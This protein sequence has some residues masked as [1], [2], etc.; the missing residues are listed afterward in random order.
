MKRLNMK[1]KIIR[2]IL[3]CVFVVAASTFLTGCTTTQESDWRWKQFN[4][5]YRPP[6]P[7]DPRPPFSF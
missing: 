5:D 6:Y 3:L 4:P 7:P 1:S 2:A